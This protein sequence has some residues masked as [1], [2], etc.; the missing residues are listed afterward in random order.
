M[1]SMKEVNKYTYALIKLEVG[2]YDDLRR[3]Y[4]DPT[5]SN[6]ANQFIFEP[7]IITSSFV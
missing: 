5:E 6:I 3:Y 4:E 2:E 7:H 1:Q